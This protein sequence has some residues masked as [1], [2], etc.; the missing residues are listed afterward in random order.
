MDQLWSEAL[1]VWASTNL[2]NTWHLVCF[3]NIQEDSIWGKVE[4]WKPNCILLSLAHCIILATEAL[5]VGQWQSREGRYPPI[6]GL[7]VGIILFESS[8][9]SSWAIKVYP[10][11]KNAVGH[12]THRAPVIFGQENL[13]V[14]VT[15]SVTARNNNN[16]AIAEPTTRWVATKV[17]IGQCWAN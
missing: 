6:R 3:V 10:E 14:V 1:R 15:L 8:V 4:R 2:N 12:G 9:I 5:R 11:C 17:D 7:H 13:S 16:I